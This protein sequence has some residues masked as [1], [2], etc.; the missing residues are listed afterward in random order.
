MLPTSAIPVIAQITTV[1]QN[2]PVIATKDWRAG[3]FVAAAA[4]TIGAVPRP[5]S[6]ENKPRAIPYCKATEIPEP[7][8]PPKIALS[9]KAHSTIAQTAGTKYCQLIINNAAVPSK[10]ATVI[11]GINFSQ[12]FEIA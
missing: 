11:K 3:F 9:L 2:A 6:L 5:D 8:A 7:I 4:A 1:D 12:T 10:Y